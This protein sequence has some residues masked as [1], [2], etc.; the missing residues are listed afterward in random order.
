MSKDGGKTA[1]PSRQQAEPAKDESREGG[2]TGEGVARHHEPA[3]SVDRLLDLPDRL[4]EVDFRGV[5]HLQIHNLLDIEGVA[6]RRLVAV[7]QRPLVLVLDV[8]S[9]EVP[10]VRRVEVVKAQI[11]R[12]RSR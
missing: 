10:Q 9:A 4:G 5:L 3:D 7:V 6:G 2:D 8:A 12:V 11:L 1:S